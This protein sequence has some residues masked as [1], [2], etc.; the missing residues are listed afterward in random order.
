MLKL[1]SKV[2]PDSSVTQT[3]TD[4]TS[5]VKFGGGYQ[6]DSANSPKFQRELWDLSYTLLNQAEYDKLMATLM[7]ASTIQT[8][9]W[10][11]T[12]QTANFFRYSNTLSNGAWVKTAGIAVTQVS[13]GTLHRDA[14]TLVT[15]PS[16]GDARNMSQTVSYPS[17]SDWCF[18]AYFLATVDTTV[19]M[20]LTLG[21]GLARLIFNAKDGAIIGAISA[22]VENMTF[23]TSVDTEGFLRVYLAAEGLIENNTIKGTFHFDA[24]APVTI[25]MADVQLNP[26]GE[27]S[28]LS[29]TTQVPSF[30][31]FKRTKDG[32]LVQNRQGNTY[33][34][35]FQLVEV[36]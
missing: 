28:R 32:K 11:T 9:I 31:K 7:L 34:L 4:D 26:G 10:M 16:G 29:R 13:A 3:Y 14:W 22:D 24:A 8:M 21:T 18:S 36:A 1:T 6:Q 35:K 25:K 12:G 20:E 19:M 15:T 17:A 30:K 23:G 27:A 33:A 5:T 2:L